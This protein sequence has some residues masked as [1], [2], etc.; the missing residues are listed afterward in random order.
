[1][2]VLHNPYVTLTVMAFAVYLMRSSGYWLA[3]RVK[4]NPWVRAWLGYVPGCLMVSIITPLLITGTVIEWVGAVITA[5]V[6]LI[7]RSVLIAMLSGMGS[8]VILRLILGLP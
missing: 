6:V 4:M 7:T 3:G 5:G 8:V 1:M 2:S